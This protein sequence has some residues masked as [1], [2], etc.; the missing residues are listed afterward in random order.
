MITEYN[1]KLKSTQEEVQT[2]AEELKTQSE[3]L[4]ESNIK[5]E[6]LNQELDQVVQKRTQEIF[7]KNKTLQETNYELQTRNHELDSIIYR[8]SH[9]LRSPLATML[10]LFNIMKDIPDNQDLLI[11]AESEGNRMDRF[12][13]NINRF[14]ESSRQKAD[15]EHVDIE[16]L[17]KDCFHKL[18][19]VPGAQQMSHQ[20]I[21]Q[22]DTQNVF[23]DE[24][25]LK[26]VFNN[27][28]TNAIHFQNPNIETQNCI[29]TLQ[30]DSKLI[31]ITFWDNGLGI[32]ETCMDKVFDMFY[33]GSERSKGSGIG[34][35][36]VKNAIEK[37]KGKISIKS[38]LGEFTQ[39]NITIPNNFDSKA[40]H[41][42]LIM[43][44][45]NY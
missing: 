36:I 31:Q 20:I 25:R 23:T 38:S 16:E 24:S 45:L 37:L 30:V 22:G 29:I 3:E 4:Q 1:Y 5:L 17:I 26:M 27:L 34:L 21:L 12:I 33:R 35:Y 6:K 40:L 9:D 13:H 44:R 18:R 43:R 2:Q 7:D 8:I 28:I 19:N 41:K 42:T 39:F 11:L 10:G 32:D 15:V 14:A